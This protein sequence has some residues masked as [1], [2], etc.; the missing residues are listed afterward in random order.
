M[1]AAVIPIGNHWRE[2]KYADATVPRASQKPVIYNQYI[3]F[4]Y[5][6]CHYILQSFLYLVS[7]FEELIEIEQK[8]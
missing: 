4:D 5:T 3:G 7:T 6:L 8:S 1:S 2:Y